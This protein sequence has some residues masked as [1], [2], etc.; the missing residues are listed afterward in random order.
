METSMDDH[1]KLE[2]E[3]EDGEGVRW[4]DHLPPH[5]YI[6]DSSEYGTPSEQLLNDSR[7]SQ[8]SIKASQFP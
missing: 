1:Q 8:T 5:K 4:R 2:V 3:V 7:T 6:K